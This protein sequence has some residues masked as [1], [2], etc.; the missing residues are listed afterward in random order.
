MI[1]QIKEQ[2]KLTVLYRVDYPDAREG[3]Q[4]FG[5]VWQLAWELI[6]LSFVVDWF[7][8]VGKYLDSLN[9]TKGITF[10][11]GYEGYKREVFT[12]FAA[13]RHSNPRVVQGVSGGVRFVE[14]VR[15][16][17][18]GIPDVSPLELSWRPNSDPAVNLPRLID[19]VAILRNLV[20]KR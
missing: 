18:R 6:P 1:T 17:Q 11:D 2:R 7:L 9:A 19:S 5:N 10:L 20:G 3:A 13:D 16:R 8:P 15:T 12:T 14:V 4:I